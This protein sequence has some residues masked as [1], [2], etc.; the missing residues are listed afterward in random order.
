[1]QY[2]T[3][4]LTIPASFVVG[5]VEFVTFSCCFDKIPETFVLGGSLRKGRSH[6]G[7]QTWRQEL[8]AC[9]AHGV[10]SQEGGR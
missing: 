6:H 8:K 5:G 7:G 9:W 1:M 3:K 4:D 10:E 2:S